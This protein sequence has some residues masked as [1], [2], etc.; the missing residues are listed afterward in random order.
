M[1]SIE[2]MMEEHKN[3][4]RMLKVVRKFCFELLKGKDVSYDDLYSMIDFIRNY[5]DKHHHGK[6][7]QLLFNRMQEELNEAIKKTIQYGMLVEHDEGRFFINSLVE[8]IKKVQDGNEESKL[9][10]IAN[11]I[12]YTNL[13]DRHIDKEDKIVYKFAKN[14]L[15]SDSKVDIDE[16]CEQFEVEAKSQGIQDKY[17]NMLERLEKLYI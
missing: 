16:K 4:R 8:A 9:D 10:V 15:S 3:I 5:A 11:A 2:L 1:N 7:E 13:L 6:E 17:I 14:N 12:A